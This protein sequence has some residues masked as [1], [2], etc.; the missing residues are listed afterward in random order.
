MSDAAANLKKPKK[1]PNHLLV[2]KEPPIDLQV[3]FH[4][5][6]TKDAKQLLVDIYYAFE[7]KIDQLYY[8]RQARKL[9][10]AN[11]ANWPNFGKSQA[12]SDPTWR[13]APLP[14]RLAN[15]RLDIGD[16]SPSNIDHFLSSLEA[17]VQGIQVDFDDGH[18]PTWRN[19]IMGWHNV[20]DIAKGYIFGIH[21]LD[22]LPLLILRPRAWN[23][24][25][26][27]V[28]I[29][30]KEVPGPLVDFALLMFH[31]AKIM[32]DFGAGP[33]FYLSKLEG[34]SEA[35][36]WNEIFVWSQ[37]KL[38]IPHGTIKACVLIENI[39]SSFEM[40]EILYELKD[41]SLGLNC[42]IWDYA[43][44]IISKFGARRKF[45]FPDRNKYVNMESHFL[46]KYMEL[47]VHVCHKRG[48][49]ATGGMAATLIHKNGDESVIKKVV[50]SKRLEILIGVDGFMVYDKK[51][52]PHINKL[53]DDMCGSTVNQLSKLSSDATSIT[54]KDLLEIP[55]GGVTVVGLKRNIAVSVLFIY[56]W[57]RGNG[58]FFLA[59]SVEDSATAEI[60]RSQI[61]QWIRHEAYIEQTRFKVNK[62]LVEDYTSLFL[63]RKN[64]RNDAVMLKS[65][66]IFLN[67][68]TLREFP[69]FITTYLNDSFVFREHHDQF[70][71]IPSK[72]LRKYLVNKL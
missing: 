70:D 48:A 8:D 32:H 38:N 20:Y 68:V 35:K 67:I 9:Q 26:H 52:V 34:A 63:D 37:E 42:G 40:E 71:F 18:C 72:H 17:D 59:N 46:K 62:Y 58:H 2:I 6:F 22:R 51:L 47:V 12:R 69:E 61:W 3:H 60:S 45:I 30:G 49:H 25:E 14:P 36:L 23:M 64:Y 66:K 33:Y 29:K 56:N 7:K 55:A 13:V 1:S 10:Y 16:V 41:H 65:A 21:Q 50:D 19:Q 27:N 57:F 5:L 44:S 53:W 15:R 39:L 28:M 54:V 43:A 31:N 24:L 11:E 4:H